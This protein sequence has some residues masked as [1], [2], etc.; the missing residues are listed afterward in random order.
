M[1][2]M[3]EMM[4]IHVAL[5]HDEGNRFNCIG[6]KSRFPEE[7]FVKRHLIQN[8]ETFFCLDCDDWIKDKTRVF[9]EDWTL[10]DNNGFLRMDL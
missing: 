5:A 4:K 8:T 3:P 9:D 2:K 1:G 7:R 10:L 6:C